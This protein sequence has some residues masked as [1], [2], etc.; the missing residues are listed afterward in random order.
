M[1]VTNE[2]PPTL[3]EMIFA[4]SHINYNTVYQPLSPPPPSTDRLSASLDNITKPSPTKTLTNADT[5]VDEDN[6]ENEEDNDE[7]NR[8]ISLYQ[9]LFPRETEAICRIAVDQAF[10]E[11]AAIISG[12]VEDW[13]NAIAIPNATSEIILRTL[14]DTGRHTPVDLSR[15]VLCLA[16]VH[17]HSPVHR[18]QQRV[19]SGESSG[20]KEVVYTGRIDYAVALQDPE[21]QHLTSYLILVEAKRESE[22]N[23]ARAQVLG[24]AACIWEARKQKGARLDCTTYGQ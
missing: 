14:H 4:I 17:V 13:S 2:V 18:K 1:S 8:A 19:R 20:I 23:K 21:T 9:K 5:D 3:D 7:E 16:E 6:S 15:R 11:V 24:Y 12:A 10:L 22:F